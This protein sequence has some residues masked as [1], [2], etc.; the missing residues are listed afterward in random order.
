MLRNVGTTGTLDM[1]QV[2]RDIVR[3][4][5]IVEPI[6][7][8]FKDMLPT[9]KFVVTTNNSPIGGRILLTHT[10]GKFYTEFRTRKPF[11][12]SFGLCR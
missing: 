1:R 12:G 8:T 11:G 4:I 10:L 2:A 7:V 9:M 6:D 3:T 5:F